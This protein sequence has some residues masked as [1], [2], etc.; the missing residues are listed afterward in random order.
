MQ[1]KESNFN[2][3]VMFI[4]ASQGLQCET[5]KE[6]VLQNT[7]LREN[8]TKS[9]QHSGCLLTQLLSHGLK[10]F[11]GLKLWFREFPFSRIHSL[12]LSILLPSVMAHLI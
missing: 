10:A 12:I 3:E 1:L 11:L 4:N 7:H 9:S 2:K 8:G 6:S 5:Q